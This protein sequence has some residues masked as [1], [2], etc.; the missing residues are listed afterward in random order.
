MQRKPKFKIGN[1][2][3]TGNFTSHHITYIKKSVPP[4]AIVPERKPVDKVESLAG[5]ESNYT[6]F[7]PH[8]ILKATFF[9]LFDSERANVLSNKHLFNLG[10]TA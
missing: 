6:F 3:N 10:T 1:H 7:F 5:H 8:T 4:L 9:F 2:K